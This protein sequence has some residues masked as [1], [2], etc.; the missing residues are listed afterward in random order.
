MIKRIFLLFLFTFLFVLPAYAADIFAKPVIKDPNYSAKFVSQSESDP[1]V[2]SAGETK[3]VIVKFK[4]V[5]KNTWYVSKKDFVSVYTIAP[6]YRASVFAGK[7]WLAKDQ[8]AIVWAVTKP[9]EVGEFR[10]NL[11]A[12]TKTGEY[13]ERFNLLAEN[14]SWVKGGYF[15]FKIKVV[16]AVEKK[17]VEPVVSSTVSIESAVEE[18]T[19]TEEVTATDT[20]AIDTPVVATD[21]AV[22]DVPQ[23]DL[24]PEPNIRVNLYATKT[25]VQFKSDFDYEILGGDESLGVLPAGT[26]AKMSYKSGEFYLKSAE[27][28]TTTKKYFR[29]VPTDMNNYFTLVNAERKVS[30]KG[31]TNFNVYRGI[32]EYRR[33]ART[34]NIY[35]I[36]ELPLDNYVAGIGETS[37]DAPLEYIKAIITAARTY[38]YV[39]IHPEGP[40]DKALYDVEATTADQLYLGV[41]SEKIT[42]RLV[43]AQ[44]DT[45]GEMV[46]YNRNPVT[47]PYFA[48][49][50]GNTRGWNDIWGTPLRPWLK[51]V[52]CP[53]DEGKRMW[54]HGVGMSTQDATARA[55]KEGWTY[56]QILRYYYSDTALEK[57]Y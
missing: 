27:I 20:V 49:S 33:S 11:H 44:T 22:S 32:L 45:Y 36:N 37:N 54:G 24:I 18:P 13:T 6:N 21:T 39:R 26:L 15:Y 38:A 46:T 9:G 42:P 31:K 57:M 40:T 29:L 41:N 3:Q 56:D 43:N 2:I 52:A 23:R 8:A 53:Y 16:K 19:T 35:V 30:W 34:G 4:N 50:D 17:V 48:H 12:P 55:S 51:S 14:K 1:I 28:T 5:G 10:I 7:D 25:E 47:T